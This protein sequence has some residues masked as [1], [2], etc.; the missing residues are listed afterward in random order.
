MMPQG[1]GTVTPGGKI[2]LNSPEGTRSTY[3]LTEK[4]ANLLDAFHITIVMI[5]WNG[6]RMVVISACFWTGVLLNP[7][8]IAS[9]AGQVQSEDKAIDSANS[10]ITV[11]VFKSGL[12]SFMAHNHVIVAKGLEGMAETGARPSVSFR[13]P[14]DQLKVIDTELSAKDRAE[15]QETM[16]GEKVLNIHEFPV[17]SFQSRACTWKDEDRLLISGDL[18]LHGRTRDIS[19]TVRKTADRYHGK[20]TLRQ[21]D[22]GIKPIKIAAGAVSVKDEIEIEFDVRLTAAR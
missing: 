17:I 15:V 20:T 22:F 6:V 3:I 2:T 5:G 9:M 16:E 14:A 12:F 19:F 10:E 7:L 1:G 11:R 4:I 13:I 18:T 21:S 8:F